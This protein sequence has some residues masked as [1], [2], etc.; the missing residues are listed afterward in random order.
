MFLIKANSDNIIVDGLYYPTCF[1]NAS[2]LQLH[3]ENG[4]ILGNHSNV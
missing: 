2:D 4:N 1:L 3:I